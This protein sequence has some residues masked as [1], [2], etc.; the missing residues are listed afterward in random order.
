[1][2]TNHRHSHT[3]GDLRRNP[4][5]GELAAIA[6]GRRARP[7]DE[8]GSNAG[9]CPFCEGHERLTPP[10]VDALR[11]EGAADTP[12]WRV[13]VV[14]NMFPAFPGGHEV[15][16][17]SPAHDAELEDLSLDEAAD[18]VLMYQRR[19][20]AQLARE[21]AAVAIVHNRGAR[22][23]ASLHHPHSQVFATPIV[24]PV[25]A[26]ELQN[27]DRYRARYGTCLLC[28]LGTDAATSLAALTAAGQAEAA[29]PAEPGD[30]ALP[31]F[32]QDGIVAWVPRAARFAYEL[33]LAP[34]EHEADLRD[35]DPRDV[36]AA[37]Q[38]ALRAIAAASGGAALN[39]WLHTAPREVRGTCHWHFEIAPRIGMP[40]GFELGSGIMIN[41]VDPAEAAAA[42]RRADRSRP[43]A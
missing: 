10:E 43:P 35:A 22:A 39:Y 28:D 30:E 7:N 32:E 9:L 21:A 36:A 17:H 18:V 5:S 4:V 40:A 25:L 31:V 24:P 1:V 16:V 8:A 27:L 3:G 20:A 15:I 38:R 26:E 42:L 19:L 13:R 37:L 23:G 11:D 41:V 6:P 12:G 14:P 33:W 2:P 34:R 29:T